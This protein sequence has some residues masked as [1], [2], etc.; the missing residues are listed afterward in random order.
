MTKEQRHAA[1]VVCKSIID[2]WCADN[3]DFVELCA[4]LNAGVAR[5]VRVVK[6]RKECPA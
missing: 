1:N 2:E 5:A 4:C 3:G 6:E